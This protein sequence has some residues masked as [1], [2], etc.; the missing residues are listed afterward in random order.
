MTL[1]AEIAGAAP[2]ARRGDSGARE[3]VIANL[4]LLCGLRRGSVLSAPDFGVDDVT[5]LFHSFPVGLDVWQT[6]LEE[7]LSR[8]EPHLR[9]VHVLP[10]VGD[11]LDLTLRVEIHALLAA[12]DRTTP[13]RFF[14]TIDPQHRVG[15]R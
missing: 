8:Y 4:E 15:V 12:A 1:F 9:D 6:R 7:S 5:L 3:A 2:P 10:I 11:E 13:T 14:A